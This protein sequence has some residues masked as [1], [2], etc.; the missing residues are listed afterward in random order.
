MMSLP[1]IG[2]TTF[3]T[4]LPHKDFPYVAVTEAYVQ[5][6]IQAGGLPLLIP[7]GL[8]TTALDELLSH[9]DGVLFTG[10][11]DLDPTLYGA[12]AHPTIH[13]VDPERDRV[14]L[15]LARQVVRRGTPFLGICRGLQTINVAL[16][17]TLYSDIHAGQPGARQHACF[18]DAPRHFLAH[19]VQVAPQSRL[20]E[21]LGVSECQVNSGHHQA[22]RQPGAGLHPTAFAPDGVIE[23]LELPEHPFGLAVQ[24]HPE[25]LTHLPEM[26]ALFAAFLQAAQEAATRPAHAPQR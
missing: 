14:E 13:G 3:H 5:A 10:G 19:T 6:I 7:L 9:L 26:R 25:W 15:Y 21:I 20:A 12:G 17:G 4:Q 23:A 16:G 18:D 22:A 24:W 8:P 1:V 2:L 11:G